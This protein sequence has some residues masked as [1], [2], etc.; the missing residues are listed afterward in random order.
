MWK[1]PDNRFIPLDCPVAGYEKGVPGVQGSAPI[2]I[3]R[4]RIKGGIHPGKWVYGNSAYVP[5]GGTEYT[6]TEFEIYTGPVK[7]VPVKGKNIPLD[8]LVGGQEEDGRRLYIARAKFEQGLFTGK[9]G[10]HLAK[11]CS[12][13]YKGKEHDI[14]EYEVLVQA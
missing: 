9:A 12:V 4:A 7:W 13:S 3:I 11:G 10:S 1:V 8:A 6:V 2:F 14:D 5:W